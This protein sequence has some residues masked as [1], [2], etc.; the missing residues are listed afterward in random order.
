[1]RF[2]N[3]LHGTERKLT[4]LRKWIFSALEFAGKPLSI[5]EIWE[6]VV[7]RQHLPCTTREQIS[8]A[9]PTRTKLRITGLHVD[10]YNEVEAMGKEHFVKIMRP[11]DEGKKRGTTIV[12]LI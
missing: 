12:T 6:D 11:R 5:R 7:L 9:G 1:M 4:L 3:R 8:M 10:I 2:H